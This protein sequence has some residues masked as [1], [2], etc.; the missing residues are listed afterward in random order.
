MHKKFKVLESISKADESYWWVILM[1]HN[2]RWEFFYFL[3]FEKSDLRFAF[4]PLFVEGDGEAQLTIEIVSISLPKALN[5]CS[6]VFWKITLLIRH[7]YVIKMNCRKITAW[8]NWKI[9]NMTNYKK[10]F[11]KVSKSKLIG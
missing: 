5:H 10:S 8:N 2:L 9:I 4:V 11:S 6:I 1:S 3:I 7:H